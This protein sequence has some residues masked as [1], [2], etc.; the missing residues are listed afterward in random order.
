VSAPTAPERGTLGER[1]ARAA[2]WNVA[3]FAIGRVVLLVTTI[4]T[5]RLLSPEDF[6]LLGLAVTVTTF[7]D[8][9]NDFG[10]TTAYVYFARRGDDDD[11][12]AD[13]AFGLNLFIG[14]TLT[15]L[16]L[17]AAP[18]VA[19]FYDEPRVTAILAVLSVNYLLISAGSI[20]DG[21]MRARLDFKMRFFAEL[22]RSISKGA[23]TI[24]LAAAGFGVWSLVIGQVAGVAVSSILFI[25]LERWRPRLRIDRELARRMM[26]YGMNLVSVGFVG[27]AAA[28]VDYVFIG[29]RLGTEALGFYTLAFRLPSL[30]IKGTTAMVG[31]VAFSAY[32]QIADDMAALSRAVLRSLRLLTIYTVPVALGMAVVAPEAVTVLF[33]ERWESTGHLLRILA[34]Y[35]LLTSVMFSAGDVYKAIGRPGLLTLHASIKLAVAAPLL[36]YAAGHGLTWVAWGQVVVGVVSLTVQLV[37]LRATL[38]IGPLETL[39]NVLAPLGAGAAMA[40][41]A[42]GTIVLL[43]GASELVRLFATTVVGALVYGT[44]LWA[45]DPEDA[46]D[47]M[48]LLVPGRGRPKGNRA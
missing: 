2:I 36:W 46:R 38:G 22:G 15:V 10:L 18:F 9:L 4:V 25:A 19:R 37:L 48:R 20:H 42:A 12:V 7:L 21:R 26:R 13:T 23:L 43:A 41:A 6:G 1:T 45:I 47:T 16:T 17:A 31:Q 28:N 3:N 32:A 14:A 27:L 35:S 39:R 24:A 33:G 11:R 30:A 40:A 29:R 5:A 44:V 34:L 8:L